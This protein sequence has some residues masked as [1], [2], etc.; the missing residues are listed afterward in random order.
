MHFT[1][2]SLCLQPW[3]KQNQTNNLTKNKSVHG[4]SGKKLFTLGINGVCKY[5]LSGGKCMP[6]LILKIWFL[7]MISKSQVSI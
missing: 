1:V 3:T 7:I 4:V 5:I 6:G 2:A